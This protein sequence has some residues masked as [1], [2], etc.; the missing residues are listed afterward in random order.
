MSKFT[1]NLNNGGPVTL[2]VA[3]TDSDETINSFFLALS[4]STEP[5][6]SIKE[7]TCEVVCHKETYTA[8]EVKLLIGMSLHYSTQRFLRNRK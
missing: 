1:F 8:E 6:I 2:D 5:F 7:K 3:K 4:K